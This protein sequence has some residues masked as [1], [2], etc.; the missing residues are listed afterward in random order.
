MLGHVE[1][2][3]KGHFVQK[4]LYEAENEFGLR[5]RNESERTTFSLLM[6]KCRENIMS[7]LKGSKLL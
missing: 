2:A 5:L 1:I 3:S 4:L 7:D 6:Q